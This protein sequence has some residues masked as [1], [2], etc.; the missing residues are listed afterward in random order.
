M[1]FSMDFLNTKNYFPAFWILQ[2]VRKFQSMMA[3]IPKNTKIL[4][5][6]EFIYYS[7]LM[8]R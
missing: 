1:C 5:L 2:H 8:F 7:L 4:F 6:R 3:N